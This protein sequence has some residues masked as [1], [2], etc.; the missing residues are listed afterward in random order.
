MGP[1]TVGLSGFHLS[2]EEIKRNAQKE[3]CKTYKAIGSGIVDARIE[4]EKGCSTEKVGGDWIKGNNKRSG[5]FRIDSPKANERQTCE[6][7][8]QPENGSGAFQKQA[9]S[10]LT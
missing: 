4:H 10:V 5:P 6:E 8:E 7:K 1:K 2:G 9:E 3:K